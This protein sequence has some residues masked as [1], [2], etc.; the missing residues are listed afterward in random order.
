MNHYS[1]IVSKINNHLQTT[2]K[3]IISTGCSFVQGKAAWPLDFLSE[4]SPKYVSHFYNFDHL[5]NQQKIEAANKYKYVTYKDNNFITVN[6]EINN[7]FTSQL[8]KTYLPQYTIA[9]LGVEATGILA[10]VFNLYITPINYSLA[11]E[12]ILFFCPT[13]LQRYDVINDVGSGWV[14]NVNEYI[15]GNQ[16]NTWWPNVAIS[17]ASNKLVQE[18]Y[19]LN[20]H[21]KKFEILL[22]IHAFKLL[23]D[24]VKLHNAKLYIFPAFN[25]YYNKKYFLENINNIVERDKKTNEF[26]AENNKKLDVNDLVYNYIPW[27]NFITIDGYN[28][29]FDLAFGQ[30]KNYDA[31]L[32]MQSIVGRNGGT[33]NQYI[34]KCGHPGVKAHT[35]L[36]KKLYELLK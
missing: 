31:K 30:E 21:S 11:D 14:K 35:L 9:N 24:W 3:L 8:Q 22:A 33:E 29:F 25:K 32:E 20:V 18:G 4:Y 7:S 23:I 12:I 19:G 15:I 34:M 28:T 16:Y 6:L 26:I 27:D 13:D 36:A 10:S 1:R 5:S 2:K 17:L